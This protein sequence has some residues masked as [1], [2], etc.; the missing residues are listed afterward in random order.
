MSQMPSYNHS[1]QLSL[2]FAQPAVS[3]APTTNQ[4]QVSASPA[5]TST[6]S[7]SQSNPNATL[8]PGDVSGTVTVLNN[9]GNQAHENRQP[10][11]GMRYI[12]CM[13]GIFPSRG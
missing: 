5:T 3:G 10:W 2:Q 6:P 1:T 9:G 8:R 11:I 13:E 4:P 12:I 7:Y